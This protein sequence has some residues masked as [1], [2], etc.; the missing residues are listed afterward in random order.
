LLIFLLVV[1]H[2]QQNTNVLELYR[3]ID[4]SPEAN[5]KTWYNSGI[6][7]YAKP[8]WKSWKYWKETV[9]HKIDMAIAW[10][11]P[12]TSPVAFKYFIF[13]DLRNFEKNVIDAYRWLADM[14]EE[15]D[16]IYLFG[17]QILQ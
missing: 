9:Y 6:G 2:K 1:T 5:Q 4:K 14:Y 16:S 12:T 10:Y 17:K 7:T 3:L 13:G 8:S 15:G 11:A